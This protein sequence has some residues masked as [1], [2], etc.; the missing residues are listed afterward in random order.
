MSSECT[1]NPEVQRLIA[2][3]PRLAYAVMEGLPLVQYP[4]TTTAGFTAAGTPAPILDQLPSDDPLDRDFLI[5]GI[6]VDIQTPN[7]NTGSLFKPEADLAYDFTSGIQVSIKQRGLYGRQYDQIPLKMLGKMC[8][9]VRP[10]PLLMEQKL[11]TSF[12]VTTALPSSAT[13]ITITWVA[14]TAPRDT[15][16]RMDINKILDCLDAKGYITTWGRKI[17]EST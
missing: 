6:D 8:S 16:F 4:F 5:E 14:R 9:E 3:S 13:N 11:L 10:M 15:V 12:F 7:F 1:C 2:L 17:F